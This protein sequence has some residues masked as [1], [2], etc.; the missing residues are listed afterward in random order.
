MSPM[1]LFGQKPYAY[2]ISAPTLGKIPKTI[3]SNGSSINMGRV[4]LLLNRLELLSGCNLEDFQMVKTFVPNDDDT[5]DDIKSISSTCS[6]RERILSI[7]VRQ[8]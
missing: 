2:V 7:G 8:R 6:S 1:E 5:D 3:S 4:W